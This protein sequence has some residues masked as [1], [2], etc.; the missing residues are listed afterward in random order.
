VLSNITGYNSAAQHNTQ[1]DPALLSQYCNGAR[2][3]PENGGLGYQVPPGIA[4]ATVPNPI[5]NLTPAATVDEGNNWINISWGPLSLTNSVSGV[6]L[7]NYAP[8]TGSEVANYIP[9]TA[10]T[11]GAAPATDF[12]GNLRKLNNAVDA[13]AV[14]LQAPAIAI[15]NVTGGPLAFGNVPINTVSASQNLTLH[16]TGGASLTGIALT[17]T[18]PYS[19]IDTGA[20]PGA[21]PD[22]GTTLAAGAN[23]TI[24][25]VFSPTALGAAPGSLAIG[26]SVPVSGSAV[27][28]GGTGVAQVL[29]ATL[30]PT[31]HN[32]GT[33]ARGSFTGGLQAFVLTN[34]GN[35]TLTGITQGALGGTDAVE[36]T[37]IRF[38]STC[39]PAG[40]GQ[41]MGQ[42]TLA[43]GAAC[44]VT[45]QFRP[46]T[47]QSTGAK[48]ATVSVTNVSGTQTSTLTGTAN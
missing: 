16:N 36:F 37:V 4:D 41:I 10:T 6:T 2:V 21:A 17:F 1:G 15:A 14:E 24:K 3:P 22:C 12:F 40:G 48:S 7:G 23:C 27:T 5:F 43:P 38:L 44:A 42:T 47:T 35:V 45:V 8:A 33:A 34:T 25:V 13:G 11:Y 39:G 9:A 31:S 46:L 26:A 20:F 18:G 32:F 19:R 30:A 29:S 28:L